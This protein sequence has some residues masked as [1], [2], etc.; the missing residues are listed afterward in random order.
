MLGNALRA[1]ASGAPRL[2]VRGLLALACA[3]GAWAQPCC[4]W[5]TRVA[6]VGAPLAL[7]RDGAEPLGLVDALAGRLEVPTALEVPAA[8]EGFGM[9]RGCAAG[10]AGVA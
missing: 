2:V 10:G 3:G 4:G 6:A 5:P 7:A 8:L 1:R 9:A